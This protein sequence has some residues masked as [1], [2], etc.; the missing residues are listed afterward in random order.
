MKTVFALVAVLALSGCG[1]IKTRDKNEAEVQKIKTVAIVGFAVQQPNAAK[2]GFN[3]SSGG[4]EGKSGGTMIPQNSPH[5]DQ[6]YSAMRSNLQ[7]NLN[8]KVM[9]LAKLQA[10]P[11]YLKAYKQT[12]EG[13]QNKMGPGE[14]QTQ[15]LVKDLMD[16]DGTRILD[17][18]GRDALIDALGV[19]AIVTARVNVVLSGTSVM[20]IGAR[21]PVSKISFDVHRKGQ[22][23]SVWFEGGIDGEEQESVG[24]T[25]FIDETKLNELAL[26]SAQSAFAKIGQTT[27]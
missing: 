5:V 8:W 20:G 10:H 13:W 16:A 12:M 2:I 6:M 11:G 17:V 15:F 27:K 18:A 19:D 21:H 4:V 14:G 1:L 7:K 23:K 26:V 25:A 24:K 22:E 9:D 3:L